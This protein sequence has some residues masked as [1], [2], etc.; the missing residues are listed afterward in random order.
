MSDSVTLWTIASNDP[1]SMGVSREEYE[2]RLPCSFPGDLS[3]PG[4]K[5]VSLTSPALAGR[6][7]I[8]RFF[9]ISATDYDHNLKNKGRGNGLTFKWRCLLLKIDNDNK[10]Q[11]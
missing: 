6:F 10:T 1:L 4:I 11:Q 5:P 2:S 8:I 7:F 3:D 9:I